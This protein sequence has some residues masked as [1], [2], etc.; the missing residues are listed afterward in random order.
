M[1]G[2]FLEVRGQMSIRPPQGSP[3]DAAAVNFATAA[4]TGAISSGLV[5]PSP[6]ASPGT[7][8]CAPPWQVSLQT[9][10]RRVSL[11][12]TPPSFHHIPPPVKP[13]N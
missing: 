8:T 6:L 13:T 10:I 7:L 1:A 4:P 11:L 9:E 3:R 5:C 2:A 12:R